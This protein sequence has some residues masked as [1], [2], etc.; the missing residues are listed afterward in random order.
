MYSILSFRASAKNLG[1][2]IKNMHTP[3]ATEILPPFSR[4]NDKLIGLLFLLLL[5]P[6]CLHAQEEKKITDDIAD[7]VRQTGREIRDKVKDFNAIDTTYISPNLYNLAFMLEHSTWYEHYRLGN[8][9]SKDPQH[10]NFSPS[11]GTK[12]G[13]YFGWRWIFLGYTFDIEDLFGDNKNKPKKKEMSL[14]I[15]SSKFGVDLYYRKTGS[16]FKLRSFDNIGIDNPS[17]ENKH[18][19]G[20]ESS[21]KGLNAYWIFNHR[22]FSYP[23]AY[24]QSTNQRRSAGS[25]M[26]GFSYS[27]HRISFDYEK[28]PAAI[29]DRINPSLK[30]SH[31]KYSDYS[32]GFG[33][34][35]NWVFAKNWVSNLSLL[36][37]IGYKKSKID[38]NDFRNESWIKDINFDLITRAGI[39][40]NNAKYFVGASLVLHTYDYRKPSLSVTNSFGTL[41]IYAGFN[42]WKKK[43][44]KNK[45]K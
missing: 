24:S 20:L 25:F 30:F 37:G 41:R 27:Q 22:K 7:A 40:Y 5:F 1:G 16:D 26:A 11:L 38:D 34:G 29:L 43:E 13:I 18:F 6:F 17:L 44:Y 14:N 15:Y 12:L 3:Y 9:A 35:Y 45:E 33:Y 21:I 31:I 42:F 10:L 32:L 19:D 8:N 28:L 39:V 36:P 23:A 2:I 4:L